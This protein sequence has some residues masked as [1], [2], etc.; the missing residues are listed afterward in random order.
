MFSEKVEGITGTNKYLPSFP[1][2][3][4]EAAGQCGMASLM[5]PISNPFMRKIDTSG[6]VRPI[7]HAEFVQEIITAIRN[8]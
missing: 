4:N 6:F 3:I 7:K 5:V 2:G 8:R 1:E